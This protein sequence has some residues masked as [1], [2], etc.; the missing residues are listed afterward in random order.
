MVVGQVDLVDI[1]EAGCEELWNG[2]SHVATIQI[3]LSE[4]PKDAGLIW[5]RPL[6]VEISHMQVCEN[7]VARFCGVICKTES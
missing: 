2:A 7:S 3:Q 6:N 5:H 1:R 4:L